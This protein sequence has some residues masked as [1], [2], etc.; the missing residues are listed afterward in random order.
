MR[1]ELVD[2]VA[3]TAEA[4]LDRVHREA[5]LRERDR[6]LQRR[7]EQLTRLNRI[8]GLIR[9]IDRALVQAETREEI[10][11]AVCETLS[12]DDGYE[13]A[14]VGER[15][16][17]TG[18]VEPRAW[19]GEMAGYLDSVSLEATSSAAEPTG[20]TAATGEV[21]LIS[22]VADELRADAWR[23][24]AM[25]RGFHSV[26][27]VPLASGDFR[28]GVLSVYAAEP[29]AFDDTTRAVLA[30]LGET[31]A[32]AIGALERKRALLDDE[33]TR[34]EFSVRDPDFPFQRLAAQV[35]CTLSVRGGVQVTA[36][37]VAVFASV[38]GAAPAAVADA[39]RGLVT[40]EDAQVVTDGEDG[41]V[42]KLTLSRPFVALTL[43][44]RGAVLR[45]IEADADGAT[46]VV[47]G[48]RTVDARTLVE[49]V[50]DSFAAVELVGRRPLDRPS[51]HDLAHL[52]F[53]RLT[54]RQLEVVRTAYYSGFFESPRQATGEDVAA[55]LDI[56]PP[57]FYRHNRTVQR[58]LFATLFEDVGVPVDVLT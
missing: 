5:Q 43:A 44:D 23:R 57:A 19:A 8:N 27:S 22:N 40:V 13:F 24:E 15:D 32:S 1:R 36:D 45:R 17:T 3:A 29:D 2:L 37:G 51:G 9:G 48:A 26:V 31:V 53:D 46:L 14:W 12:G 25:S 21:T 7:N 4:A 16:A 41:G 11:R 42:V 38:E 33:G 49:H 50:E 35:D 56:S 28:Y 52:L 39:A 30:E 58:K 20:R 54:D 18:G 6:E 55:A 10:D 34:L 47:E